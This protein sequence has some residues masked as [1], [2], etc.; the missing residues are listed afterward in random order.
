MEQFEPTPRTQ[1][2]RIPERGAFDKKTL[3]P[4]LD[5]GFV[6]HVAFVDNGQPFVLPLAYGRAGDK[7]YLHGSAASR[8]LRVLAAGAPACVTVTLLDGLVLARSLFNHSMN[9]RCAVVLGQAKPVT[10]PA[11]KVQALKVISDHMLDGR[12]EEARAP[13]QSEMMQTLVV[14][15]LLAECSAKVRTGPPEDED[16]DYALPVWAGV[17]PSRMIF[18]APMPDPKLNAGIP[19]PKSLAQ[20]RGSV[21]RPRPD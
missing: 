10:D 5:E 2:H 3:Y 19:L 21:K 16:E 18:E 8:H 20:L 7:L 12:W 14:E 15:L 13:S 6:A 11:S 4:I 17:V 9:Y 1:L